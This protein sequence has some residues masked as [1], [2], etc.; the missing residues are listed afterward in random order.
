MSGDGQFDCHLC[1]AEDVLHD[2]RDMW[3]GPCADALAIGAARALG[4][5]RPAAVAAPAAASRRWRE[6]VKAWGAEVVAA[7][8]AA[9]VRCRPEYGFRERV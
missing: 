4:V 6:L 7:E 9:L 2:M 8:V 3:C 1:D 5:K